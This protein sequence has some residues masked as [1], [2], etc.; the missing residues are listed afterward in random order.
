MSKTDT[1]NDDQQNAIDPRGEEAFRRLALPTEYSP[2]KLQQLF[3]TGLNTWV[4][5]SGEQD[6]EALIQQ[7]EEFAIN[8]FH[9]YDGVL[10]TEDTISLQTPGQLALLATYSAIIVKHQ[11]NFTESVQDR[12]GRDVQVLHD[13]RTHFTARLTDLLKKQENSEQHYQNVA[14]VVLEKNMGKVK[15]QHVGR[16]VTDITIPENCHR[17]H[18]EIPMVAASPKCIHYKEDEN[19][20]KTPDV[21][22]QDN[23]L[24]LP[25]EYFDDHWKEYLNKGFKRLLQVQEQEVLTRGNVQW[26]LD[27]ETR[28]SDRIE[29]YQQ[30]DGNR[31][32]KTSGTTWDKLNFFRS[33]LEEHDEF[34]PEPERYYTV[35][36]IHEAIQKS[37]PKYR[38]PQRF[39]KQYDSKQKIATY[40]SSLDHQLLTVQETANHKP[41]KYWIKKYSG[42]PGVAVHDLENIFK[43]PCM[44]ALDEHL[45]EAGPGTNE[46]GPVRKDLWNFARM[47][48]WLPGY[49][50][51]REGQKDKIHID[52]VVEDLKELFS[53]YDWYDEEITEEQVRYEYRKGEREG[54]RFLPMSC[55]N[56][57]M[58]KWCI[59]R[60]ECQYSIYRSLPFVE[61]MYDQLE[62]EP[63]GF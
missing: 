9:A 5:D 41:D 33:A 50:T 53:R 27:E 57:D 63:E 42:P 10:D 31:L 30:S 12:N 52:K 23:K 17:P 61:P 37:N 34:E 51:E 20:S 39:K 35:S 36:E 13:I 49:Y 15:H 8:A 24:Y 4:K 11:E 46:D 56:D 28:I 54:K 16:V 32:W 43:L 48:M 22:F 14:E 25:F 40:L 2:L 1:K 62:S 47:V 6:G 7:V 21:V 3:Q 26:L 18:F 44:G 59:G 45:Q 29:Q 38:Q 19:G 58:R 55:N 60:N